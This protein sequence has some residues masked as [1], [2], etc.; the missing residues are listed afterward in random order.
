VALRAML[1]GNEKDTPELLP[2]VDGA[3]ARAWMNMN[4]GCRPRCRP[5][6]PFRSESD[7]QP[8]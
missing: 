6:S 5:G 2:L 8:G 4:E 7:R 3:L 1:A